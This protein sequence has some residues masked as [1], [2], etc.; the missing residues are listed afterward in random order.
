MR[1]GIAMERNTT[2]AALTLL[3]AGCAAGPEL[4]ANDQDARAER[5]FV[6]GSN[7]PKRAEAPADSSLPQA[8]GLQV[9]GPDTLRQIQSGGPGADT[10]V[11]RPGR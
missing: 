3:L 9:I 11:P 10:T 6:T 7:I 1:K 4:A 8:M 2:L 5:I